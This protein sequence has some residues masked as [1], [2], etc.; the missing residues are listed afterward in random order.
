MYIKKNIENNIIFKDAPLQSAIEK[1]QKYNNRVLFVVDEHMTL[2]GALSSGDLGKWLLKNNKDIDLSS[3]VANVCNRDVSVLPYTTDME[4]IKNAFTI[5]IDAV[6]LI[7]ATGKLEAIAFKNKKSITVGDFS[8]DENSKTMII[9]EIGNNHNGSMKLAKKLIDLAVWA[10]ADCIKFQMRDLDTLYLNKG[11]ADDASEDLGSQYVLDLL[12]RFSLSKEEM[13]ELFDY[14]KARGVLA[15]CTPWDLQS[16]KDLEDYGMPAYKVSSADMTNLELLDALVQTRKPL[17]ISSGMSHEDEIKT[18]VD[19]LNKRAAEYMFLHCNST[20]PTPFKDVNLK[21]LNRLKE[22]TMFEVG[23]S[24]HER[25]YHIPIAAVAMGAKVIEKHFTIDK[26][27]EGNDH[28]VSLLPDEFKNMV[29]AIRDVESAMG[30]GESKSISQGELI[31]RETLAKSIVAKT[32]IKAGEIIDEQML[33]IKSP[34]KGLQPIYKD[35]LLGKV[36]NR[37]FKKGD[38][39]FPSDISGRA[40]YPK[41]FHFTLQ[42]GVPVRFHDYQKLIT[43]QKPDILEFHLSY[44]DLDVNLDE[45]MSRHEDIGLVVHT[46]ELFAN[47]H[48]LD[49]CA[50]EESYRQHSIKE[51]QRVVDLT[52]KLK[53]YF[54]ATATPCIVTNMGGFS[55]HGFIDISKRE[56]LYE[57]IAQSLSEIDSEGVEII[58]QTM[59]P[60]P[61]H[62]GGQSHHN[63]FMDADEIISFCK[64]HDFRICMDVAHTK[65]ACNYFQWDFENFI[66]K[67]SPFIAHLHIVDAKGF[68]DEGLQIGDGEIN[69][70]SLGKIL[71]RHCPDIT[72]IPEIWQGHKNKGEGFWEALHKLEGLF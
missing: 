44:K 4:E 63:L 45:Y 31:N 32:E 29:H 62:F 21:Y 47:D 50:E 22:L 20:Y 48:I 72:F 27:M 12:S 18:V 46:P 56:R 14:C 57:R 28:K 1:S 61:W 36:A 71:Q 15:L 54:P 6:P 11:D 65:L 60:F 41:D 25:G 70:Q 33:Q 66:Q 8:I 2:L 37:D 69:F 58:A 26:S 49:L 5:K 7:N 9:A 35:L 39:F 16:L 67:V 13:F 55:K 43:R 59:P 38:F 24:G 52:R 34:G 3:S 19:F 17:L 40:Y 10:E 64:K 42:W 53:A 51:L 68:D 23:Y 30:E